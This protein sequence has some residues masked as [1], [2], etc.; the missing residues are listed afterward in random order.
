MKRNLVFKG[1]LLIFMSIWSGKI[2]AGDDWAQFS[3][4]K[5]DNELLKS[6]Q[7]YEK[8]IAVFIGNSITQG[9][10]EFDPTFFEDNNFVGR[11]ISGQ[12]SYQMLTRFREDVINLKPE[13][14][15]INAGTNDIAENNH[16]YD[17]EITLGN[18]VSMVEL[19]KAN[20]IP[21]ILTSVLPAKRFGWKPSIQGIEGKILSLNQRIQSYADQHAI[22]YADYYDVMHDDSMAMKEGLSYD[23]VHPTLE[24]YKV[25]EETILPE[26]IKLS[27]ANK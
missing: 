11:G 26:I 4:Y 24:G 21:V 2:L 25:M 23:G 9:W 27:E 3:R 8:P 6:Q 18:I 15:I 13:I 7:P 10:V 22:P 1:L 5:A 20:N 12:T 19:A 14:V 16:N 17:E